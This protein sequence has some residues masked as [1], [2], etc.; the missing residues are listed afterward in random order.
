MFADWGFA[1]HLA[2]L[3]AGCG[4]LEP[5]GGSQAGVREVSYENECWEV[6][7]LGKLDMPDTNLALCSTLCCS[8]RRA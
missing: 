4:W 3:L 8:M 2:D 7:L 1:A 5:E 6:E